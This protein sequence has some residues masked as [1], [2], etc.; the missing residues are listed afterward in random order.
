MHDSGGFSLV[1]D[2]S[3]LGTEIIVK[4]RGHYRVHA[5]QHCSIARA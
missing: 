1:I 2:K 3:S 4:L 5:M